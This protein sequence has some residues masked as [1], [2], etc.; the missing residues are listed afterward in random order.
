MPKHLIYK[1][2]MVAATL[3]LCSGSARVASLWFRDL[4]Q[5]AVIALLLGA[6]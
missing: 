5:Q 2:R 6:I 4:D 1:L 3:V